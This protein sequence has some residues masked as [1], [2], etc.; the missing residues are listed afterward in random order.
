MDNFVLHNPTRIV[1]GAGAVDRTGQEVKEWG[2]KAFIVTGKTAVRRFGILDRVVKSLKS[3][4]VE[5][6]VYDQI[7]SN[8][9]TGSIDSAAVVVRKNQCDFVIGLGGGSPM[10]AAKGIAAL[11]TQDGSI[12]D[13]IKSGPGP[14]RTI[15][16]ALPVMTI[17]TFAGS[18]SEVN[19]YGV[20]THWDLRQ[21]AVFASDLLH[22]KVAIVD[23]ALTQTV[24]PSS[25][26]EGGIDML[27]HLLESYFTGNDNSP[28]QDRLTESLVSVVVDNLGKAIEN[29]NDPEAR[30]ALSWT[31]TLALSGYIDSGR[32]GSFP[33]HWI[34]HALSGHYDIPHGRGLAILLPRLVAFTLESRP[35]RYAQLAKRVFGPY[36]VGTGRSHL[37]AAHI[38][39]QELIKWMKGIGMY[40]SLKD[41]GIDDAL[42]EKMADDTIHL[43]GKGRPYLEN[44]RK[45]AKE[46]ILEILT[47]ALGENGR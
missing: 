38:F 1:F 4:G 12:W 30:T 5:S 20:V 44:P 22:P 46:G 27:C 9:R 47:Q 37:E 31:S 35:V 16:N 26:G 40:S 6:V 25:T 21:K 43:Y 2:R 19:S 18:G 45:I 13:Y 36:V 10:D 24:S 14:H 23:P 34:E 17:P 41:F 8:P 29:G 28:V 33:L 32:E 15:T 39:H 11:A 3:A 42:F 7:E